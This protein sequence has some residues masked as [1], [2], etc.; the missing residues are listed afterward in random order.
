MSVPRARVFGRFSDSQ[1][2][3]HGAPTYLPSLPSP[4]R[5]SA[6][7]DGVRSCS[8]LRG[9]PGFTPGSL[10]ARPRGVE[11]VAGDTI[12]GVATGCE[13]LDVVSACRV[14]LTCRRVVRSRQPCRPVGPMA[15]AS[16]RRV[17][18]TWRAGSAWHRAPGGVVSS[19]QR[20]ALA[21]RRS[22]RRAIGQVGQTKPSSA[23]TARAAATMFASA[24]RTSA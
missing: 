22:D 2:R 4:L 1:A 10:L 20:V 15:R 7:R 6:S 18:S 11:P 3:V 14:E 13:H 16:C 21:G 12:S 19:Y 24:G 9:S 5:A 8:P 23:R 17:V